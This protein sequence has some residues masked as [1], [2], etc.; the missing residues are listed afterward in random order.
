MFEV[1]V[2]G[3]DDVYT[4]ES[5]LAALRQA[6]EINQGFLADLLRHP[7]PA[8][9]VLCVATVHGDVPMNCSQSEAAT[10]MALPNN[11]RRCLWLLVAE[12]Q[13]QDEKWGGPMHDDE[14]DTADFVQLV[15]DYAGWARVMAGMGSNDKAQRRMVQVAAL[16]LAEV[17]RLMRCFD[18]CDEEDARSKAL[19]PRT[20]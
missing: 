8:D 6:N 13:R 20:T 17:E 7:N 2:A 10:Y 11:L 18:H 5:E 19:V 9:Q 1:R 14:N 12:R 16:A 3:P 15:Q 4:H